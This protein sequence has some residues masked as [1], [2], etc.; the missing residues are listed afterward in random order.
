MKAPSSETIWW[1]IKSRLAHTMMSPTRTC[2]GEGENWNA[3]IVTV[4]V[5]AWAGDDGTAANRKPAATRATVKRL[6]VLINVL[7]AGQQDRRTNQ[8]DPGARRV[9][10]AITR[11]SWGVMGARWHQARRPGPRRVAHWN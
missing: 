8:R 5:A 7:T 2:R 3:L 9:G 6:T 4:A 10:A 1:A 11:T